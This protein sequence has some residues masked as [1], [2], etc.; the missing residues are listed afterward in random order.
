MRGVLFFA[1]VTALTSGASAER[2]ISPDQVPE[3]LRPWVEWVLYAEPQ[4]RCPFLYNA[5]DARRCAW[6]TRLQLKLTE[7]QGDFEILWHVYQT[8]E[9]KL[10][11][12]GLH[13]P[14]E[15]TADGKPQ[16]VSQRDG[17]PVV[18]LESGV[19][20]IRGH[21]EWDRLPEELLIPEDS[22]IVSLTIQGKAVGSPRIGPQG[23]LW[24]RDGDPGARKRDGE[25]LS[26]Q[27]FRKVIDEIPLLVE[28]R[29]DLEVSGR[30]REVVLGRALLPQFIPLS[31]TSPLP[32]RLEPD[33]R[34]RAQVRPGS[35]SI[36][37]SA[38]FPAETT[39]IAL[40]KNLSPWP[41]SEVWV[42]DARPKLRLVEVQGVISIDPR[43]TSLPGEWQHLPTYRLQAGDGLRLEVIRRGDPEPD[44]DALHLQREL[45]LDFDGGGY[46]VA[47]TI[48][49][50]M[51]RAWRLTAGT[52]L[53]LGRVS[54]DG[55]AQFIT[56]LPGSDQEGVEVRRGSIDL[57]ADSRYEGRVRS[58]NA[59]GW[60]H[61]FDQ[62]SATLHLPPGWRLFAAAGVDNVPHTWVSR[63]T[64]LDLFV[65]LIAALAF[66]HLWGWP[67]GLLALTA[68]GLSWHEWDAPRYVW[69]HVLVSVALARVLPEGRLRRVATLYRNAS[70]LALVAIGVGFLINQVRTG[71]YPQLEQPFAAPAVA[72]RTV[73]PPE[74]ASAP[75]ADEMAL[76]ESNRDAAVSGLAL[77]QEQ[78][79]PRKR[80][81]L[82]E[83]KAATQA[84]NFDQIDPKANIQTG[85]GLPTWDWTDISLSWNGPVERSQDLRLFLIPPAGNLLLRLLRV[86]LTSALVL[87]AVVSS[88]GRITLRRGHA[89]AMVLCW[90]PVLSFHPQEARAEF[91]DPT[92]L[93]ELKSRLLAPAPCLPDCA[94]LSRATL[95]LRPQTLHLRL[96][97]HALADV[98]VPL[99]AGA[100]DWLPEQVQVDGSAPEGLARTPQGQVWIKLSEG[101]HEVLL[102]GPLPPKD[103]ITLPLPLKP[104]RVEIQSEGWAVE[105]VDEHGV[106]QSQLQFIRRNAQA[107]HDPQAI[108][109]P[110]ALPPFV[111]LERTLRLGLDWR[112]ETSVIRASPH[113]TAVLMQVPLIEGESVTTPEVRVQDGKV[114]V[115]MPP[116]ASSVSWTSTLAKRPSIALKAHQTEASTEIWRVDISPIWHLSA[117]GIAEVYHQD[118]Q[119][120]R[121]PEWQPW[122]GEAIKLDLTRPEG[123]SGQTLTLDRARLQLTPGKRATDALLELTWRS[124]QG[125][126]HH[127]TLPEEAELQTVLIDGRL[128]PIRQDG[129][130]VT[131]PLT[132][133]QQNVS[134]S[135]RQSQGLGAYFRTP[136]VDLGAPSVNGQLEAALGQDRWILFTG[137]PRLGPAVLFWGVLAVVL[138]IAIALGRVRITPLKSRHW[139]L[140]GMGLTQVPI[141]TGLVIV[142]WLLALGL[143]AKVEQKVSAFAFNAMQVALSLLT[144]VA[145]NLL[146]FAVQQGLLGLP[147]MQIAG[148][149]STASQL[150]WYI[151]RSDPRLPQAWF[152][153]VPLFGYRVLMLAWALWLAFALL[154]W[155]KWGW[156]CFSQGGLWRKS[157]RAQTSPLP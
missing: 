156:G 50:R 150:N 58:T 59:V 155:L 144:L 80:A 11:G 146:F 29:I 45:W 68:L 56:R 65:V 55:Q 37:L 138:L 77:E 85:P 132:P 33:G 31:L 40:G 149:S 8:S 129:R 130:R 43:Q 154:G 115:N 90:L 69:V 148:N 18:E 46:T 10:P 93:E 21:L 36:Q 17:R 64:L 27:I 39:H 24:L 51:L 79:V 75:A 145:L 108:L 112:V 131:L 121:L 110:L 23:K 1:L 102:A 153:S 107:P 35:W 92:L 76:E 53:K 88:L 133:G 71:I 54:L 152:V 9:V 100:N 141:W 128:Q 89:A 143:R 19:H 127:L 106:P 3:P 61:D 38:R 72:L 12:G 2:P 48:S 73:V 142:A 126:Q 113:D 137:G 20:E 86:A 32:T 13:W 49:G 94:Y 99:P 25:R 81:L 6:P 157:P 26:L 114:M 66:G 14:Q 15:V 116:Q 60:D 82:R 101:R 118:P 91:P 42:F 4:R 44:P 67:W 95:S 7:K 41:D 96:Q 111:K 105:G 122:P 109:E 87:I 63:W 123:S 70:L 83:Q 16:L 134:L 97:V 120:R 119:G 135:W 28:T 125:G 147:E 34:L 22:G 84:A 52:D 139:F 151:D 30:Q 140:L 117:S 47:D 136:E 57:S 74:P 104:K 62:V 78:T 98:A 103:Q 124:S 5:E